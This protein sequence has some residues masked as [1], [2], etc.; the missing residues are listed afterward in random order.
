MAVRVTANAAESPG[1]RH[2]HR[3]ALSMRH[4]TVDPRGFDDG[5]SISISI[6]S[7]MGNVIDIVFCL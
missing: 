6:S 3:G 1:R 7:R 5:E 4:P 2:G